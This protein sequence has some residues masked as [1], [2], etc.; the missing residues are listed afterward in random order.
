VKHPRLRGALDGLKVLDVSDL[1]RYKDALDAGRQVGWGYY[2]PYLVSRHKDGRSAVLLHYDSGSACLFLW[3][4]RGREE[5][6][7]LCAPPA[8]MDRGVLRRCLE[9]AN[10][11]NRDRTAR[12]LRIDA[13]DAAAVSG[14]LGMRVRQRRVQ[15]LYA[16]RQYAS[17]SGNRYR[18]VR[19]NVAM[20]ERLPDVEVQ[21]Y[22][23]AHA[24]A[25]RELLQS[26]REHHRS[27]HGDEGGA[28]T[29]ARIIEL[30]EILAAP[31]LAGEVVIVGG[32]LAAFTFGGEIR[33]GVGCFLEAKSDARIP[34]L[35]YFSRHRFLS[36]L[37]RFVLVNDG[38]D[39]GRA[40]LRQLKDS[41]RPIEIHAEYRG[42]QREALRAMTRPAARP[43][44]AADR[45]NGMMLAKRL[46]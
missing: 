20:V 35:G 15:Y 28:A 16:P 45:T 26:W 34:G 4:R 19:R 5:Q 9:R 31:D 13:K 37:D 46:L 39:V 38:S 27:V 36:K 41:F 2:F 24:P 33:S 12:V 29:S 7:E 22:S 44:V 10:E 30:A 32:R 17:L 8:P 3:R 18:T 11:F 6:L 43:A 21:P 23:V 40:G 1:S 42:Y 14:V 25:C